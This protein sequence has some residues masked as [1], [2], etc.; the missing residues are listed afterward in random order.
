MF[1]YGRFYNK[2]R[3]KIGW[4]RPI[5]SLK[6]Q[7]IFRKRAT[8]YRA[9]LRKMTY[10]NKASYDSTPPC[11][12]CTMSLKELLYSPKKIS[13][14]VCWSSVEALC[15][16]TIGLLQGQ[17]LCFD[18]ADS[19]QITTPLK[20]TESRNSIPAV[21]IWIKPKTQFEFVP[22]DTK[23]CEFLDLV[24]FGGVAISVETAIR[25]T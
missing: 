12:H 14:C 15:W 17:G 11:I 8:N 22:R 23:T 20:S 16:C 18:M 10:E 5:G 13:D 2:R 19:T 25:S 9:L 21:Q 6:L 7:V 3:S 24:D 1:W 4:R